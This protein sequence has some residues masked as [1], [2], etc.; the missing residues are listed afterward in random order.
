MSWTVTYDASPEAK[1]KGSG[2]HAVNR[3]R[4]LGRAAD[5][6]SGFDFGHRNINI[7]PSR[8]SMNESFVN[9]GQGDFRTPVV[10]KDGNGH[11]RPPSAEYADYRDARL[12]QVV[13]PLRKDAVV[14]R[15][16][17]LQLDPKWF[18]AHC[19]NWKTDGLNDEARRLVQVQ[20]DWA[21]QEF[22]QAN[23]VGGSIDLDETSPHLQLSVVPVTDDGRLSQ[24][25]FFRGPGHF[26]K[27]RSD[28]CDALDAAGYEPQRTVTTRSTERTSSAEY[29]RTVEKAA[30]TLAVAQTDG[31]KLWNER[32]EVRAKKARL[33]KFADV[34]DDGQRKL[35]TERATLP[36]LR[37]QAREDGQAEA[38]VR[39]R[40]EA[41]AEVADT[42]AAARRARD[43]ALSQAR[44]HRDA[45]ARLDALR[46]S[47]KKQLEDNPPPA[48]PPSYE[49]MRRDILG[50]QPHLLSKF[51]RRIKMKD[52]TTLEDKFE[53]FQRKEFAKHQRRDSD[54]LGH[55]IGPRYETWKSHTLDMQRK[56]E[57]TVLSS[58]VAD[59]G[60]HRDDADFER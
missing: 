56:T 27:Q 50:T 2:S 32:K 11:D 44:A 43:E 46:E 17:M 22:G 29:A 38:L 48:T 53:D 3:D 33:E 19:P 51:L 57:R 30:A 40:E 9:D 34:L 7:D 18:E 8:S 6:E 47:I 58:R 20:L 16:A 4:H 21:C 26:K 55:Y 45:A 28:L 15:G 5:L 1:V 37:R 24:K 23:I 42:R 39:A 60:L 35:D 10:T 49:D 41:A 13:K 52:G 59:M 36:R 54:A 25:D 14:M 12:R 31:A